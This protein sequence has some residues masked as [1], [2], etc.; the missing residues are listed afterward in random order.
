MFTAPTAFRAIKK[1]DPKGALLGEYDLSDLRYLFLAGERLDPETYH[2]A[3][4]LL[5]SRS[6][7]TGGRPRRAGRSARTRPGSS[8]CRSSRA[9]RRSRCRAGTCGSLD[10]SGRAG[11]ARRG[12]RDR[13]QAAV[14]ARLAADPVERRRALR[15]VVHVGVRRLLPDR[16]R[17]ADRRGRL[18]LRDGSHGR[19]DQRRRAPAL[20]RRHGGGARLAPGRR[21]VRR[22]RCGGHHEG[23]GAAWVRRAQGGR[24][25]AGRGAAGRAR[26][27]GARADRRGGVPPGGRRGAGA[28]EDPF[29]QDP[30]QDDARHRRRVGRAGSVDDR[31]R[32]VLDTLRP[33]LRRE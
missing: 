7:T 24:G 27:D 14:A 4:D 16:R 21:R 28:A 25:P 10:A 8:C 5:G 3:S 33:V 20:D 13:H 9:R 30:A 29:G 6:S 2:W 32:G 1:E 19:R 15:A 18:R 26:R 12:R 23:A 31:R 22:H 17:R 11:T